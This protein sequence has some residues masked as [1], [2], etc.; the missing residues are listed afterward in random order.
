[1]PPLLLFQTQRF[2]SSEKTFS[3][4][5]RSS[6]MWRQSMQMKGNRA[7]LAA[8][9]CRRQSGDEEAGEGRSVHLANT[10]GEVAVADAPGAAHM[11]IDRQIVRRVAEDQSDVLAA[12]K[13]CIG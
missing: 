3:S 8:G 7:V 4:A 13:R 11:A 2:L 1:M 9:R 5:A 10:H 6:A 12:K